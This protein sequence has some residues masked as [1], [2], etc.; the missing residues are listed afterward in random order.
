MDL[1]SHMVGNEPDDTLAVGGREP[2]PRVLSSARQP[3][4]P[5]PA[6]RVEHD[7][8]DGRVVQISCDRG[9]ERGAQLAGAVGLR[10]GEVKRSSSRRFDPVV[11]SVGRRLTRR[12]DYTA[13]I[14]GQFNK[15]DGVVVAKGTKAGRRVAAAA[16]IRWSCFFPYLPL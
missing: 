3:V 15:R 5:E 1:R 10:L 16:L 13:A 9:T 4:D 6:V 12:V 2:R 14:R 7:L 11:A 8:D